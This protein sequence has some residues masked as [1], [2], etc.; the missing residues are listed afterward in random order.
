PKAIRVAQHE[1]FDVLRSHG[2]IAKKVPNSSDVG[3][4]RVTSEEGRGGK[5][6]KFR[7]AT[8]LAEAGALI[9]QAAANDMASKRPVLQGAC[10]MAEKELGDLY[11][12]ITKG[13]KGLPI[14]MA[15]V[16]NRL[17]AAENRIMEAIWQSTDPSK[18][19]TMLKAARVELQRYEATM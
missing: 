6:E 15:E 8:F 9:R 13:D 14:D 12:R 11:D 5:D 4:H 7:I 10:S 2:V 19:E 18:V 17:A 1:A 16:E 3:R